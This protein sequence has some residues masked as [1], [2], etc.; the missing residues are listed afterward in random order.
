MFK[1]IFFIFSTFIIYGCSFDNKTGI[2][3]GSNKIAKKNDNVQNLEL[4]FKKKNSDIKTKELSKN[5]KISLTT[6]NSFSMWGQ[7]YQ[8]NFNNVGNLKFF[9]EGNYKKLAKISKVN[10]NDNILFYNGN[11]FFSDTKGNIGVFSLSQNKLIYKYNFYK[12]KIRAKK[13]IRLII[14]NDFIIA[15]DNFGYVYSLNYKKNK[16]NWAKNFLVPF[17]SN[18]KILNDILFLSDEKNKIILIDIK[19]GNKI[20]EFYTQPSKAVSKFES[21]LAIDKN[22][23]LLFLSTNGSLYSLNLI[24]QKTINWIQNFKSENDII[25][26][27][28][29]IRILKDKI[30]ISTNNS[31]SLIN[32]N[33]KRIWDLNIK[34]SI[35]PIISG[36]TIFMVN[37]DNYLIFIDVVTG[38]IIFSKNLHSFLMQ[39]FK[40][41]FLRKIRKI[42]H[43][44]LINNKLLLISKNSYFIEVN[45]EN[46]IKISSIK[47]NPFIISSDIIFLKNEMIFVSQSKRIYKVN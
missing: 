16:L 47:K 28:N 20:E 31:I 21:N 17:R 5:R 24:N 1:I 35:P 32:Q 7:R 43:I 22:N 11:L 33:G 9:N 27:A 13:E 8:N 26:N 34:S 39:D 42:N 3:T 25:F 37:E 41:N 46:N 45:L 38:K 40:K 15:A 30:M 6:P 2:W 29:P 4:I 36:N 44:S 19:N 12:K 10:I 23:N 14:K 18:L